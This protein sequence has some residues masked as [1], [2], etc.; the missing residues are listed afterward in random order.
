MLLKKFLNAGST[1]LG[2]PYHQWFNPKN[3]EWETGSAQAGTNAIQAHTGY[4]ISDSGSSYGVAATDQSTAGLEAYLDLRIPYRSYQYKDG[5]RGALD[6]DKSYDLDLDGS[7]YIWRYTNIW[8]DS[9]GTSTFNTTASI[10]QGAVSYENNG[11]FLHN[12]WV[13]GYHGNTPATTQSDTPISTIALNAK[14]S[15]VLYAY[16]IND[17]NNPQWEERT[18]FNDFG[19]IPNYHHSRMSRR[20]KKAVYHYFSDK[21]NMGTSASTAIT[22]LVPSNGFPAG[23]MYWSRLNP[24]YKSYEYAEVQDYRPHAINNLYHGGCKLIGSD[25]NMPVLS[26]VDGG[27]VVEVTDTNPNS[28]IITGRTAA[29][30]DIS[31]GGA[32]VAANVLTTQSA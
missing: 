16:G 11:T 9:S 2:G 29:G 18:P 14:S 25:F 1:V 23:D 8:K 15:S 17:S 22:T 26:T 5:K 28:L 31:A 7:R 20:Y 21:N 3:N 19:N 30:G 24:V 12:V 6:R 32:G 10:Q 4:Q 27:P 13:D